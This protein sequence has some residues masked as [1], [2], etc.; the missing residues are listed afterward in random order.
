MSRLQIGKYNSPDQIMY[1][2]HTVVKPMKMNIYQSGEGIRIIIGRIEIAVK[3]GAERTYEKV[4][5]IRIK[6]IE[7]PKVSF[8]LLVF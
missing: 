2:P 7:T 6:V 8:S 1:Y 5:Q 4:R 3:R